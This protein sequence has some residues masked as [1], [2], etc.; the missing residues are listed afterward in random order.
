MLFHYNAFVVAL[1]RQ[2]TTASGGTASPLQR[3]QHVN[4]P[5]DT[6]LKIL[7]YSSYQSLEDLLRGT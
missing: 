3:P 6:I 1:S 2:F 7:K 5:D 4:D